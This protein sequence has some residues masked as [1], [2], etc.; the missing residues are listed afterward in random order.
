MPR[1]QRMLRTQGTVLTITLSPA[2]VIRC[3]PKSQPCAEMSD[4]GTEQ[5]QCQ[6]AENQSMAG[7]EGTLQPIQFHP[8]QPWHGCQPLSQ[9]AYH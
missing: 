1:C 3:L 5:P 7:L 2:L 8:P 6:L 4:V 9:V